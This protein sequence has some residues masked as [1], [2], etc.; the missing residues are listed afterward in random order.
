MFK[1]C[2]K[3]NVWYW[4]LIVMKFKKY[5]FFGNKIVFDIEIIKKNLYYIVYGGFKIVLFVIF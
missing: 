5:F 3:L 4:K 2:I 1:V